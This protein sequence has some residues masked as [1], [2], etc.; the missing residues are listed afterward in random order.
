MAKK[1][2]NVETQQINVRVPKAVA[3][4]IEILV[5]NGF[6]KDPTD[7]VYQATL[8]HLDVTKKKLAGRIVELEMPLNLSEKSDVRPRNEARHPS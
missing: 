6:Y 7:F 1:R 8:E 3:H 2:L 4:D 5:R